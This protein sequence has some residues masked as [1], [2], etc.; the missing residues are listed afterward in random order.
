MRLSRRAR[1][2]GEEVRALGVGSEAGEVD[3]T[4]NRVERL[5]EDLVSVKAVQ[6]VKV[7]LL[8]LLKGYGSRRM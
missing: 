8:C 2:L 7:S 4:L 1:G 5:A 6:G 3:G